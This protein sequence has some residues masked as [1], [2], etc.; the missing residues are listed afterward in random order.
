MYDLSS[1]YVTT[2]FITTQDYR[3]IEPRRQIEYASGDSGPRLRTT[4]L[5]S[6]MDSSNTRG[7]VVSVVGCVQT[8]AIRCSR[9]NIQRSCTA[10]EELQKLFRATV[11]L[12][13]LYSHRFTSQS[14]GFHIDPSALRLSEDKY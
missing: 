13:V 11:H 1:P 14:V 9:Y 10:I 6:Y 8:V 4:D 3:R 12:S 5:L 7:L 2:L